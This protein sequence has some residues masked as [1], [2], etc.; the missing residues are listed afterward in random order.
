MRETV[1]SSENPSLLTLLYIMYVVVSQA[2]KEPFWCF[3]RSVQK[4]VTYD[5]NGI[6]V[7]KTIHLSD[8]LLHPIITTC[9][10]WV[11][12]RQE[13]NF[14]VDALLGIYV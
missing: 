5:N 2:N 3:T 4:R 12:Q 8:L 11:D 13:K 14:S 1:Q 7:S 6:G 10:A 9:Y